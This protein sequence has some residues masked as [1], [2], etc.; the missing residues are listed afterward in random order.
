MSRGKEVNA[1]LCP[2][3][4]GENQCALAAG[5]GTCWCYSTPVPEEV[6][7]QVPE[8]AVGL[9]C[10]CERCARGRPN[11]KR[12]LALLEALLNRR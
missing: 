8:E 9:A 11:S 1:C 4:G 10:V 2:L 5:K 6:R 3:C 12:K 7:A